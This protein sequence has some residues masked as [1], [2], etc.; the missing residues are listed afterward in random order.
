[1]FQASICFWQA[2]YIFCGESQF[3]FPHVLTVKLENTVEKGERVSQAQICILG[4][5]LAR[6]PPQRRADLPDR[7]SSTAAARPCRPSPPTQVSPG[8]GSGASDSRPPVPT[9]STLLTSTSQLGPGC[10]GAKWTRRPRPL[11]PAVP[12]LRTT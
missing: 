1:L 2:Y 10:A 9:R 5:L 7:D 3:V 6:G 12:R 11:L 8:R 4:P